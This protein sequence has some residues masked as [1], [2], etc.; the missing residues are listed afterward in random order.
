MEPG[1]TTSFS[2]LSKPF[3]FLF[4]KEKSSLKESVEEALEEHDSLSG[5][6]NKQEEKFIL[7]NVLSFAEL[8]VEDVMIPRSDILAVPHD[9]DFEALKEVM[10]DKAHTRMPVFNGSLDDIAGFIHVRD[11]VPILCNGQRFS[12]E[13]VLRNCLFVPPSM[14]LSSILVRM[15]MLRVHMAIVVDE[16]GGT[17]GLITLEDV[18][19]EI[20]GEI[21]DEHDTD[22]A[23]QCIQLTQ[24]LYELS[25]RM[26]VDEAESKFEVT[27]K[28]EDDE[29]DTIGGLVFSLLGHVPTVGEVARHSASKL[30]FE[31]I[32]ADPRR[33]KRVLVRLR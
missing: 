30:E 16:Y 31:V 2:W 22:E 19:E 3:A 18:I 33:I 13:K 20:I 9:I 24:S 21:E 7:R 15:Q 14:K 23:A 26:P 27:L 6:N 8:T 10:S 17:A 11:L 5:E 25:A 1:S 28:G 32:E 29:F 12:M 4:K